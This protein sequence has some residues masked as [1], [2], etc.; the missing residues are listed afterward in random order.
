MKARPA[1]K[2]E[3]AER[4]PA[5]G[6]GLRFAR[7]LALW[8]GPVVVAW[9]AVTPYYNLFLAKAGERSARLT[10]RPAVT[11]IVLSRGQEALISRTDTRAGGRLP[12]RMRVTDVHFPLVLLVTLFLAVPEVPWRVRLANLGYAALA[13]ALF[14]V[15]DMFFWVKFVYAT[16]LGEWSLREYGS[17]ARNF[18]GMGKHLLD[19]PVKLALPLLLWAAFYLS[20]FTFSNLRR[21]D[22]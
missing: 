12:Y 5:K 20:S 11:R 4:T 13:T 14:H 9:L 21:H 3:R 8:T 18:W 16:Q 15:L 1:R 22:I 17:F 6:W 2:T 10:E 7:N 19:L